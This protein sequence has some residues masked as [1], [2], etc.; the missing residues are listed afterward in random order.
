MDSA[1]RSIGSSHSKRSLV[2][3][4]DTSNKRRRTETDDALSTLS[5]DISLSTEDEK[6]DDDAFPLPETAS[7]PDEYFLRLLSVICPHRH[8]KVQPAAQ[9][10]DYFPPITEAQMAR[11][12]MHMVHLV[13]TN[14]RPALEQYVR[15]H[16][17]QAL[18]ASNRFGESL[19]HLACRRGFTEM[20]SWLLT[21]PLAVRVRDD[22]GRTPLHDAC[23]CPEPQ[24]DLCQGILQQ[25][26]SLFLVADQR[27]YTPL[28]YARQA[29]AP[30]WCRFL[31]AQRFRLRQ[32]VRVEW[33]VAEQD[34][35]QRG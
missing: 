8:W 10:D 3:N 16:G 4:P 31:Y 23:W 28:Q 32:W 22:G 30:V 14:D 2:P 19:L 25:D 21:L 34:L 11:Y 5:N 7:D 6:N 24:L 9:L 26:P 1:T 29:D 27:G 17:P 15:Q 13:R 18:D 20:V 12:Q 33:P 35:F